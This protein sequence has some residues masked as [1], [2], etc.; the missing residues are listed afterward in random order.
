MLLCRE[1]KNHITAFEDS[2][3]DPKRKSSMSGMGC[4]PPGLDEGLDS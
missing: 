4:D 1:K 2:E 3:A